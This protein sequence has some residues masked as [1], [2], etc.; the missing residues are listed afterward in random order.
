MGAGH[1]TGQV[2]TIFENTNFRTCGGFWDDGTI[3]IPSDIKTSFISKNGKVLSSFKEEGEVKLEDHVADRQRQMLEG[4][5]KSF[6]ISKQELAT[7]IANAKE[8]AKMAGK[9]VQLCQDEEDGTLV[10]GDMCWSDC[11]E[12]TQQNNIEFGTHFCPVTKLKQEKDL[13]FDYDEIRPGHPGCS[14]HFECIT[15]DRVLCHA[16]HKGDGFVGTKP[17]EVPPLSELGAKA[18]A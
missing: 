15:G 12:K 1:S 11:Y 5:K 9:K 17:V 18:Q 8:I 10:K 13:V 4:V 3:N 2:R 7:K 16:K 14:S 6:D